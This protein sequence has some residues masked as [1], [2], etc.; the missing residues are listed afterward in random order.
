M[1]LLKEKI[2]RKQAIIVRQVS[3]QQHS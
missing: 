2:K 1:K 3:K